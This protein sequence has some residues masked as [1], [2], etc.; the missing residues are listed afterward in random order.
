MGTTGT[1]RVQ[2]KGHSRSRGPPKRLPIPFLRLTLHQIVPSRHFLPP[3]FIALRLLLLG[4]RNSP[5]PNTHGVPRS[6]FKNAISHSL[7]RPLSIDSFLLLSTFSCFR[8]VGKRFCGT[9]GSQAR[10]RAGNCRKRG[11][12]KDA[13]GG[14]R[15]HPHLVA[16]FRWGVRT[17]HAAADWSWR[18]AVFM[19]SFG[20]PRRTPGS[21][22]G[23]KAPALC[24]SAHPP[25]NRGRNWPS[26]RTEAQL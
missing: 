24:R 22:T 17:G 2:E 11:H 5:A 19:G 12:Q 3:D 8:R 25:R 14:R 10:A 4:F 15:K 26:P 16:A 18:E 1:R 13:K 21:S 23:R 6:S 9:R 20:T 7:W